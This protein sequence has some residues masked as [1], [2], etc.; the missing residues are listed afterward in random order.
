MKND[1][2]EKQDKGR[3]SGATRH[4]AGRRR[5]RLFR[6]SRPAGR[7]VVAEFQPDAIEI[8]EKAPPRIARLTLYAVLA[9]IL[10]AIG[11]ATI[12]HVDI[13]VS[14]RGKLIT[15]TPN[16]VV[17]PLDASVIRT[18]SVKVGD[19]VKAGQILA[20]LDPTFS[21]ADL[22]QLRTRV[23][24]LDA[25][26]ARL[27]AQLNGKDYVPNNEN[28]PEQV[29]QAKL[30][31]QGKTYYEAQNRKFEA[32]IGSA[33]VNLKASQEEEAL[34]VQRLATLRGIESMREGLMD[35]ALGSK[36]TFL[37]SKDARLEVEN[38]L[39]RVRGNEADYQHR[40]ETARA[41]QQVFTEE[42]RRKAYEELVETRAK[43][44]AAKEDRKKAELRRDL[45]VLRA[46]V[47]AVV[48]EIA[49]RTVGSVVKEAETVF[50]LVPRNVPLM[51]EVT[52]D[53]R[54]I[55]QIAVGQQVRLK[56]EAYPFQKYGA[57]SGIVRV[58]S[59][60][61]F[62]TDPKAEGPRR[63][64]SP[65]YRVLVD[66]TNAHMRN[67]T[68]H[69]HLMPGMAVTAELITGKR[70]VISYFLYPLMRGMDESIR[71]P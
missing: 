2:T 21:Q 54:D 33:V 70:S 59:Q 63:T 67:S 6:D 66:V 62:V 19:D 56:L 36:L 18:I 10:A 9:L 53:G 3:R 68:P 47:D 24:G 42:F 14:A 40:V 64:E 48:L 51:A 20:T 69:I 7:K 60:D 5:L 30:F 8:G 32:Q 39:A 4:D 13:I 71:E 23:A 15:N 29:L 35:K 25:A 31:Y 12:S 28:D 26:V 52:V 46:P 16:V 38:N 22:D 57:A 41:E 11:W 55:G 58:I 49:N 44:N 27:E 45:I 50:V 37:L 61:S 1:R 17:Q 65:Y 43:R 34:A